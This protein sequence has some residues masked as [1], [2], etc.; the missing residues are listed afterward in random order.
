M[1]IGLANEYASYFTTP[2]EYAAQ[3]YEGASTLYGTYS[4]PLLADRLRQLAT[5]SPLVPQER[6]FSYR[7]G[8]TRPFR[9]G[10]IGAPPP[11][12]DDGLEPV[13]LNLQTGLPVHDFPR[14]CWQDEI[15]EFSMPYQDH[16]EVTPHVAIH[17]R[18]GTAWRVLR[19]DGAGQTDMGLN[20]ITM[21]IAQAYGRT[22]W[23]AIWMPPDAVD[24]TLPLRFWVRTLRGQA[25]CSQAFRLQ[26]TD[27]LIARKRVCEP[28]QQPLPQAL[29]LHR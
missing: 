28:D 19:L 13:A 16:V 25:R 27:P 1:L 29:R 21:G 12:P 5:T 11:V 8:R 6:R 18:Q 4:G 20:F 14:F 2:E 24:P 9:F 22:T 17:H 15:P 10:D 3:H 26:D 23:C 7:P